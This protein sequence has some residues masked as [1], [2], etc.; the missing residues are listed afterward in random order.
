MRRIR[1]A[2]ASMVVAAGLVAAVAA[3]ASAAGPPPGKGLV[4]FGTW[5][6]DGLGPVELVGPRG[7]QGRF[8]LSRL[9]V[10]H[11]ISFSLDIHGIFEGEPIDFSKTYGQKS[12]LTPFTCT[13]HRGRVA[14][15]HD[16]HWSSVSSLRSS[17]E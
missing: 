17:S 13:Q 3:P 11:E 4:S 12:A 5:N 9:P 15:H 10:M 6:C 8:G 2:A 7:E 14:R 1:I 16:P